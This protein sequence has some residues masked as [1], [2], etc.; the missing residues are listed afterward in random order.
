MWVF[1]Y[2]L[3]T[4]SDIPA[5]L[6]AQSPN[7]VFDCYVEPD[8]DYSVIEVPIYSTQF[9]ENNFTNIPGYESLANKASGI[10][11]P[12]AKVLD[13]PPTAPILNIYPLV[14][15]E[16]QVKIIADLQTGENIGDQALEIISIGDTTEKILELKEYQDEYINSFLPPGVL[17]FKNE[18]LTEIRNL[19][20]YRATDINLNVENYNDI[21][22][23]FNPLDNDSVIVRQYTDRAD[24]PSQS[25]EF[26]MSYAILDQIQPNQNY[27]YTCIVEDVHGN[28]SNPSIIY[29]VRLLLEKGLLIPE[30]ETV[31]PSKISTTK[32][33]KDLT[34]FLQ[35][36]PSM[37]QS[38]PFLR[39]TNDGEVTERS[40]GATLNKSIEDQ[41]YIV[42]LTSKDTGRKFDIKLNFVV[43]IDG[44]PINLGT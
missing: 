36:G 18:G 25:A 10:V 6:L 13:R 43:R 3:G 38:E 26:I 9:I 42:R 23:S 4:I 40:I 14:N 11:Y 22:S 7:I 30:V 17:E 2:Y 35:I 16:D 12:T 37:I 24:I 19:T 34:R 1:E 29:R 31:S 33:Q 21:Y 20:L 5:N 41:S 27:Y 39:Q 32:P 15:I 28:P 44:A 8:V